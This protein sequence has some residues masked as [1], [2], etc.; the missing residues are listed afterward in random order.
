ME[1]SRLP[2]LSGLDVDLE[3]GSVGYEVGT[4]GRR[5]SGD[6]HMRLEIT[7][8]ATLQRYKRVPQYVVVSRVISGVASY[9]LDRQVSDWR[10]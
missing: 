4:R 5:R 3:R 2:S 1:V 10:W 6:E 9:L 7:G 8:I